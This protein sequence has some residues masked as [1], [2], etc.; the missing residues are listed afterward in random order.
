MITNDAGRKLIEDAE[1]CVLHA[2][3]CPAGIWTIGFGHTGDVKEG[4]VIT[5]HEAEVI[6]EHD[7]ERFEAAVSRICPTANGNQFSAMVSLAYNI[8]IAAFEGSSLVRAFNTG[9]PLTAANMFSA[10]CHAKVKG[11]TVALPGL[12]KRRAAERALFLLTPS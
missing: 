11:V 9:N 3:K 4:D 5:R 12:V 7:L 2:Y 10:W 8:G 1:L 6:F